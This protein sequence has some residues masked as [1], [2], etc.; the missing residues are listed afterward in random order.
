MKMSDPNYLIA[1][2]FNKAII[3]IGSRINMEDIVCYDYDKCVDILV[4]DQ[5]MSYDEALEWMDYNVCGAWMG[6][7][8][9]I[10]IRC[11]ATLDGTLTEEKCKK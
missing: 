4:E 2:G 10:F 1:D 6:D 5:H 7:K 11:D 9:P 3:G 8:T